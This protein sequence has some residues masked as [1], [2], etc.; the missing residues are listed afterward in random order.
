MQTVADRQ[1]AQADAL[2]KLSGAVAPPPP[3]TS[4]S[5][6]PTKPITSS[7]SRAEPVSLASFMG[8]RATGPR[9]NKHPAQQDAHDPTKF[10]QRTTASSPHP[11]FGRT[12]VAMPG[13]AAKGRTSQEEPHSDRTDPVR[14]PP[15]T[16]AAPDIPRP[17]RFSNSLA[18]QRYMEHVDQKVVMPQKT[19]STVSRDLPRPRT[20]STP[21]GLPPI[22]VQAATPASRAAHANLPPPRSVSIPESRNVT[23]SPLDAEPPRNIPAALKSPPV[24]RTF[25]PSPKP[26]DTTTT[27]AR[28]PSTRPQSTGVSSS[29]KSP[30]TVTSTSLARPIQPTPKSLSNGPHIP[31]SQNPS[32]AFLK[33]SAQKDPTPSLSRLKGRG[34]VQSMVKASSQL[35][36]PSEMG[37]LTSTP[38]GLVS[39]GGGGRRLS[40]VVN[41]WQQ[42][43]STSSTPAPIAPKPIALRK[44]RTV[45]TLPFT[46]SVPAPPPTVIEPQQT[47]RSLWNVPS[48]PALTAS[49]TGTSHVSRSKTP[50]ET[51][52]TPG[53]G[54]SSTL[55]SYIKPMKTGDDAP[56]QS[57][58]SRPTTPAAISRPV[59]PAASSRPVTP[60]TNYRPVFPASHG[61]DEFGSRAGRR[62]QPSVG[63]SAAVLPP[64]PG[65]PL[66]H[67]RVI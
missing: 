47:G 66:S 54:S 61:L 40:S 39:G 48:V 11:V 50:V 25:T 62:G 6:P 35:E 5:P 8:A 18:L 38:T 12:G 45:E 21:T 20:M 55:V 29:P 17:R 26:T 32:P 33:P 58:T 41:R 1:R 42:P 60:A 15:T 19:G 22:N 7:T 16:H 43:E 13:L 34:F 24:T 59:T 3:A 2:L 52:S 67:V 31:L 53:L 46:N 56:S 37:S 51:T 65:K 36:G 28:P 4:R 63:I 23:T 27:P 30:T 64:S 44:S 49:H 10:E 57:S 14:S 9:L